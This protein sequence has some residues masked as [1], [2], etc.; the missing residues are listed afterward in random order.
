LVVANF[1]VSRGQWERFWVG[2]PPEYLGVEAEVQRR[3]V[4][5]CIDRTSE[6]Q[7]GLDGKHGV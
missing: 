5:G 4:D 1:Q 6:W 2:G 7:R 3:V